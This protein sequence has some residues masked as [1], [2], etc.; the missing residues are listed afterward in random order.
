[1]SSIVRHYIQIFYPGKTKCHCIVT[2]SIVLLFRAT[3]VVR[4]QLDFV[5]KD[6]SREAGFLE[7]FVECSIVL[8]T[9]TRTHAQQGKYKNRLTGRRLLKLNFTIFILYVN[10]LAQGEECVAAYPSVCVSLTVSLRCPSV[11]AL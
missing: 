11:S 7:D 8:K 4:L 10:K 5:S 2:N 1:M 9:H 3:Y 6:V